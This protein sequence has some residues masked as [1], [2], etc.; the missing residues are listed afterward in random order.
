MSFV[1]LG[2]AQLIL[3]TRDGKSPV[4]EFSNAHQPSLFKKNKVQKIMEKLSFDDLSVK[5]FV[6]DDRQLT[7]GGT[8]N[9]HSTLTEGDCGEPKTNDDGSY[10]C[11]PDDIS[12]PGVCH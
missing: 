11:Y 7:N 5:S 9:A 4:I 3:S 10:C 12:T 6:V 2:L 8:V 1:L